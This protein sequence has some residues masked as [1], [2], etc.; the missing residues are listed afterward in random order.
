QIKK[1]GEE[2]KRFEMTKTKVIKVVREEAEKM[3][4]DP[5]TIVSAKV[6]DK[7]KKAWDA[8]L[9]VHKRQHTGKVK[10]LMELNKKRVE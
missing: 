7:F 5:K 8:E 1:A 9:Q 10:R 2:A 4:L 3:G 6:G